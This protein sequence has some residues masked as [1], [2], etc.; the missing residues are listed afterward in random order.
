MLRVD[1]VGKKE[2]W[3][4]SVSVENWDGGKEGGVFICVLQNAAVM[5]SRIWTA[6]FLS[7]VIAGG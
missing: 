5:L 6:A 4:W 3:L 1:V 2:L 7:T